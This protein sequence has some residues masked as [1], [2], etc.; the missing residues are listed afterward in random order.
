MQIK[1]KLFDILDGRPEGTGLLG[2]GLHYGIMFLIFTSI[3][4]MVLDTVPSLSRAY[5]R[6]FDIIE[7]I[8][9][10]CFALEYMIRLWV[11]TVDRSNRYRHSFWG[12]LRYMVTPLAIID[13]LAFLPFYLA[14]FVG[15]DFVILRLFRMLR[16]IKLVR[17]SPALATLGRVY[18][19]ERKSVGAALVIMLALMLFASTLM[20]MFEHRAQPEN[21]ASIPHAMWW[22]MATLTTVGYGD[23]TP[24]TVPGQIFGGIV[25]MMGIAMFTLPAVILATGL[26]REIKR[27]DFLIS[28][29]S[30]ARIPL[31]Q[32]LNARETAAL[33]KR[34]H[35]QLFPANYLILHRKEQPEA[36]YIIVEG[37][38]RLSYPDEEQVLKEGDF[39]GALAEFGIEDAYKAHIQTDTQTRLLVLD[40]DD[41]NHMLAQM[42]E[43]RKA[44]A[45]TKK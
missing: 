41:F 27:S 33:A 39:F 2:Y 13:L 43:L 38:V 19:A 44:I 31:F 30:L 15:G 35:T 1:R 36:L 21:F 12:R 29:D 32:N 34:L 17:Y 20:W 42:P 24:V 9:V 6:W 11:V 10:N 14:F 7:A 37:E 3:T 4:C 5:G 18:W 45:D 25:M 22:A 23:M 16:M 40:L 28:F 8:A 26:A